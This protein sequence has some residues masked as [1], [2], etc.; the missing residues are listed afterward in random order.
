M[1]YSESARELVLFGTGRAALGDATERARRSIAAEEVSSSQSADVV[2]I[3]SVGAFARAGTVVAAELDTFEAGSPE[4]GPGEYVRV[5]S[6]KDTRVG[7]GGILGKAGTSGTLG[8]RRVAARLSDLP[9]VGLRKKMRS[10]G[11]PSASSSDSNNRCRCA[12]SSS[13][14]SEPE[15]SNSMGDRGTLMAN[16]FSRWRASAL[17]FLA[18]RASF[19]R[20]PLL[21]RRSPSSS[22]VSEDT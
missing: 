3:A 11:S 7:S 22:S 14:A 4:I 6:A 9:R 17:A 2:V 10:K 8:L 21:A 13:S 18:F 19:R 15:T 1:E 5:L 20:R 12:L 16:S